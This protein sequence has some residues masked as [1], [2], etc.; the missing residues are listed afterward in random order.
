VV[1]VSSR[2]PSRA[3]S[4]L[5]V[6]LNADWEIPSFAAALVKLRS[7]ATARK[8][9]MSLKFSRCIYAEIS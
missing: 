9:R 5:I 4:P 2:S 3:C 6:W 1:R 7:C 8:A